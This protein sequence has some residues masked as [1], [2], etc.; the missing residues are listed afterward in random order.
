MRI[1]SVEIEN[2]A[3]LAG[4]V[5]IDFDKAPIRDA[6]LFAITGPTGSGKST[7]LDAICL[8]LFDRLPRLSGTERSATVGR[9][10]EE[11]A[12]QLAGN[13][14]RGTLRHGAVQGSAEVVFS[15]SDGRRYRAR[16]SV[17]RAHNRP[18]GRLQD[19]KLSLSDATTGEALGG[20][21]TETLAAIENLV[22]LT[23]EQFCR[24]VLLAQGEFD[25]FVKARSEE[26]SAL[27]EKITGAEIY[28]RLSTAAFERN[29]AA[30]AALAQV[31]SRLGEHRE[32]GAADRAALEEILRART[33]AV[34]ALVKVRGELDAALRWYAT[35][36]GLATNVERAKADE[37]AA[38]AA[39][40]AAKPD[41]NALQRARRAF[42]L[43]AEYERARDAA[44]LV[45]G[46]D[47]TAR[48][49]AA[50]HRSACEELEKAR[51][52]AE[53]ARA[54]HA[55]AKNA[56]DAAGP[57]LTRATTLD[58]GI[59]DADR[60]VAELNEVLSRAQNA[61]RGAKKAL[62][63]ASS[64]L[65]EARSQ[66][67]EHGQW[68]A[69]NPAHVALPVSS[70]DV[71]RDLES[72][73]ELAAAM[74]G[75]RTVAKLADAKA[76]AARERAATAAAKAKEQDD[77]RDA[78]T[79]ATDEQRQ[80]LAGVDRAALGTASAAAASMEAAIKFAN[81]AV[82]DARTTAS[83]RDRAGAQ[84]RSAEAMLATAMQT[85][86]AI[87]RDLSVEVVRLDEIS[88]SF[89][90]SRIGAE[91]A[92]AALRALLEDGRPCPVCGALEH[93]DG[94]ADAIWVDRLEI[95]RR[96]LA[97]QQVRV[98]SLTSGAAKAQADAGHAQKEIERIEEEIALLE[99]RHGRH[100]DDW[101]TARKSL[102][103]AAPVA[104]LVLD[105]LS[106]DLRDASAPE[107]LTALAGR[108]EERRVAL[109]AAISAYD[110]ASAEIVCLEVTARMTDGEA[111]KFH[112]WVRNARE[113]EIREE[114][115]ANEARARLD[116]K[117][118]THAETGERLDPIAGGVWPDWRER[119]AAGAG[120]LVTACREVARE[121][122]RR[123][124]AR[125]AAS[126]RVDELVPLAASLEAEVR[127]GTQAV[128]ER[129]EEHGAAQRACTALRD[130]RARLFE[131]RPTDEVRTGFQQRVR[132]AADAEKAAETALA[133]TDRRVS[134]ARTTN[135]HAT[136]ALAQG[137]ATRD[138]AES[139]LTAV[140]QDASL[141]R[142]F[143]GTVLAN[144]EA[145]LD[146]EQMRL[147]ALTKAVVEKA[148][149]AL[150]ACGARRRHH[151]TGLPGKTKEAADAEKPGVCERLDQAEGERAAARRDLQR[152]DEARAAIDA[153][154][155]EL[156][157]A[158]KDVDLWGQLSDLIGSQNGV[159]FRRFA[160]SITLTQLLQ[161]ANR[162][163]FDLQPRYRLEPAPGS[164]SSLALQIVDHDM[165]DEVRGIH[166][167]SG[168]ERFLV[169]LALALGLASMSGE[170]GTRVESLFIDE[171]F[172]AL[173]DASLATAVSA[174]E[175][176]Q[177]TGRKVGV[178]SHVAEMKDRIPVQVR[179]VPQG[180]GRSGIEIVPVTA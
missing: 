6:G 38:R 31:H 145:A 46:L 132:G 137:I 152:D 106:E 154:R 91:E 79:R 70:D 179:V 104:G 4:P 117:A 163:L 90:L 14:V 118:R 131:G 146:A 130:E 96:R 43:R 164:E 105:Q 34:D 55:E 32:L 156:E 71:V 144:G 61:L 165:C 174:L 110:T 109:T 129:A 85:K 65:I 13:D 11:G 176:L 89:D 2:I 52:A 173:D 8:A 97:E 147:D 93:P 64:A 60:R 9:N 126:G 82:E 172:G 29:R 107:A 158:K 153:L 88:R 16:W 116:E 58:G 37:S 80:K 69:E 73:V 175:A 94:G 167:L 17:K 170:Q 5:R 112:D 74:E 15:A 25:A 51:T 169:S 62:L 83:A 122:G 54:A 3:S 44:A 49:A 149:A 30:Q 12:E 121:V 33:E 160:Q 177:A 166:N 139:A 39:S 57:D 53:A 115:A 140:L 68:L 78:A 102:C 1:L 92:T 66:A 150:E 95:D 98:N 134:V 36:E 18:T 120:H 77:A 128:A 86:E 151:E 178:I 41:R 157:R 50:A 171:G 76:A 159:K 100:A 87:D 114:S 168:G 124:E 108:V 143:V 81:R 21:K 75:L 35:D 56:F 123:T 111:R 135:G 63:D 72:L 148:A 99:G 67:A 141:E 113:E 20:T 26:R 119:L 103:E 125:R 142:D 24:A 23:F 28:S 48:E 45:P 10:E 180:G 161:L 7:I 40:D 22:G 42:S 59:R 27:L 19:E 162:H 127:Y 155:V 47:T 133:A 101:R 84:R 138:S 136:E